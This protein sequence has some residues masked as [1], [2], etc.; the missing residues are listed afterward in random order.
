[1]CSS[2]FVEEMIPQRKRKKQGEGINRQ[3]YLIKAVIVTDVLNF[4]GD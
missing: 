1:M 4:S 3:G 2:P